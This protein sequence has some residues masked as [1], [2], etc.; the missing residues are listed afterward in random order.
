MR[1]PE[2]GYTSPYLSD[3]RGQKIAVICD[4]CGLS[5]QYDADLMRQRIGDNVMPD[6]LR[7]IASAE[8]CERVGNDY[9]DRCTLHYD[10]ARM[11]IPLQRKT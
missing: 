5:R 8:G 9:Y 7:K 2:R 6:L 11:Q 4:T 10:K 3:Y 1:T